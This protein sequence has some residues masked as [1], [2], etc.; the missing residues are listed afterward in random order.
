MKVDNFLNEEIRMEI[1]R[2]LDLRGFATV[3]IGLAPSVGV[4]RREF[5]GL[6]DLPSQE[7]LDLKN[8]DFDE[9]CV[10]KLTGKSGSPAG[11]YESFTG[12]YLP[13][14]ERQSIENLQRIVKKVSK[15]QDQFFRVED[16]FSFQEKHWV[17]PRFHLYLPGDFIGEHPDTH[18]LRGLE[19][20]ERPMVR[21]AWPISAR[22]ETF[23][24]GGF[25]L[26]HDG[27]K[28]YPEEMIRPGEVLLFDGNKVHGV[29]DVL[30]NQERPITYRAQLFVNYYAKIKK[31]DLINGK[32]TFTD[33]WVQ[34][35]P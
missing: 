13:R 11:Y 30:S 18:Y 23:D 21:I 27:Q 8:G 12:I 17:A 9:V 2:Q 14:K 5:E 32:C 7:A 31:E 19:G 29:S 1:Y 15:F 22:G 35:Y 20:F 26:I 16:N 10:K 6:F 28:I 25:Y 3:D 4:A 33:S 24:S 34:V